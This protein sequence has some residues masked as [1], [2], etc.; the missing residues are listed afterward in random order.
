M[1]GSFFRGLLRYGE[2]VWTLKQL[3]CTSWLVYVG[4]SE[5]PRLMRTSLRYIRSGIRYPMFF[6]DGEAKPGI[7]DLDFL[8]FLDLY[9]HERH[10]PEERAFVSWKVSS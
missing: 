7:T 10:P 1:P 4:T 3:E 5:T 2:A 6:P 8:D 9:F